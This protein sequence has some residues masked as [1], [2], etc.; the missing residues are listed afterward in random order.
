MENNDQYNS[1]SGYDYD[2]IIVG[3]GS[4]GLAHAKHAKK[5]NPN[6]KVAVFDY[7]TP[8][9]R[10]TTWKLGGTCVNVGCIPKKLMHH[11][12]QT[13]ES[14][15]NLTEYGLTLNE[16]TNFKWEKMVKS[17][18]NYIRSLNWS[19]KK[20]LTSLG[21]EYI[22]SYAMFVDDH[23]IKYTDNNCMN[24]DE[25]INENID[26][27]ALSS[28]ITSKYFVIATGGRPNYGDYLGA[29][30]CLTSDDLFWLKKHPGKKILVV[31]GGYISLECASFLNGMGCDVTV[32]YRSKLLKEFDEQCVEQVAELMERRGVRFVKGEPI[33]FSKNN[34]NIDDNVD[35]NVDMIRVETLINTQNVDLYYNNVILAIGRTPCIS[36][37]GLNELG[38]NM[39]KNKIIVND[40]DRTNIHN[41]YAIGDVA[42]QT[43]GHNFVPEL[44]PVAIKSGIFLAERLFNSSLSQNELRSKTLPFW[45]PTTVFT[46]P[47]YACVGMSENEA[48]QIYGE[49]NVEVWS[50]RFGPIENLMLHPTF[51]QTSS[52]MFTGRN[53]W[54]R[55]KT[56][57]KGVYW[58]ETCFNDADYSSVYLDNDRTKMWKV[59]YIDEYMM[60][61]VIE[62]NLD[63]MNVSLSQLTPAGETAEY[64]HQRLIKS[65]H[66]CKIV[67]LKD[68]GKILGIHFVG[69]NAGDVIQGFA[70]ACASNPNLTKTD[71]DNL[72]AIHPIVAEEFLV[73]DVSRSSKKNF[74]KKEGCGGGSC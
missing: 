63:R 70:L 4:G 1:G 74:L 42:A 37:F 35:D 16:N 12:G 3:G 28:T 5:L 22:N 14:F 11:V 20:Q 60:T 15:H 17:I 7:V 6:L 43:A 45:I 53:L 19:Y 44:T 56:I 47:E 18:N 2:V 8:S 29:E 67:T 68:S 13:M 54:A 39:T 40:Q 38:I 32:L 41:I 9:K 71:F 62:N 55:R 61:C 72:I 27:N 57:A 52:D 46:T 50:S 73:L 31:G 48:D 21:I 51:K 34:D 33:K 69:N 36:G 10:G 64:E 24:I 26:E 58:D 30:L 66:L 49:D 59:L 65:D 23:T 25:N